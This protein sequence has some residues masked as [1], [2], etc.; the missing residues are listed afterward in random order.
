MTTT[1]G[2]GSLRHRGADQW[3]VRVSLGPDPVSGRSAVHSVTVRGDLVQA[4]RQRELLAAQ[5]EAI[6]AFNGPALRTVAD[7]LGVWLQAEHDWKPSTWQNYRIA[8]AR[9]SRDPLAQRPPSRLSPPVMAAA[10]TTWQAAG[11]PGSTIALHVRTL[12]AVL[13]WAYAQRLIACQPLDGMRGLPQPEPRRDVPIPVVVALLEA[14]ALEVEQARQQPPSTATSRRVHETEQVRLLLRLAADTGARRG[15]LGA[16]RLPDL[17]GRRLLIERGVS[18][19]VVTTTKTGRVR[20]ITVGSET[21]RLWQDSV[22]VWRDL[23]PDGPT[24]GP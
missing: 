10:V 24:F 3:E 9:L 1:R 21:A 8:A 23:A 19:E 4:Q 12:R 18:A 7:L 13:G 15:E 22:R 17:A 20:T 5:A 16:L 14:A 6:R 11:V 2:S